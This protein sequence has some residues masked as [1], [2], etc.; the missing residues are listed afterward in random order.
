M[1]SPNNKSLILHDSKG[2]ESGS[3]A[4]L[5]T[6]SRFIEERNGRPFP[7]QLHAIWLV[8]LS[9]M[10]YVVL[11]CEGIASKFP[12]EENVFSRVVISDC[13]KY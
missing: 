6:V 5:T 11:S 4:N 1:V 13:S 2:L 9:D 8:D 3:D 12:L 10:N 7:E